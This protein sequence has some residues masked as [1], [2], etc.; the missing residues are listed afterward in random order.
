MKTTSFFLLLLFFFCFVACKGEEQTT[1]APQPIQTASKSA[2]LATYKGGQITEADFTEWMRANRYTERKI[3][4]I[5]E[6]A[7][8]QTGHLRRMALDLFTSQEAEAAG[9]DKSEAFQ[10]TVR[11]AKKNYLL[12]YFRNKLRAEA[13]FSDQAVR[14]RMIFFEVLD[15]KLVDGVK[16]VKL[17]VE[18][19]EKAYQEKI[20]LA[21]KVIKE[22]DDGAD[23]A[24]L[25][26]DYSDDPSKRVGGDIGYI[27]YQMK[28]QAF[29]DAAFSLDPGKYTTQPVRTENGVY[30]IKVEDRV[31]VNE[32][33]I[34]EKIQDFHNA[35]SL[36]R[37]LAFFAVMRYEQ[38]LKK[39]D[40]AETY[41]ANLTQKS[42][43]DTV[44]FKVSESDFTLADFDRV[45]S[46]PVVSD[47]ADTSADTVFR[48]QLSLE[49]ALLLR[50]ALK[51]GVHQQKAFKN[52]WKVMRWVALARNYK[53][54]VVLALSNIT[55]TEDEIKKEQKNKAAVKGDKVEY[56][57]DVIVKIL[58]GRKRF[59]KK[60]KYE[61]EILFKNEFTVL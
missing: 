24:K 49:D 5:L 10:T 26:K 53:N 55:I 57:R 39:A 36:K 54:A 51:Q 47:E 61:E 28:E 19:V 56:D 41:Y 60:R 58:K 6:N 22:L 34:E 21:N 48:S 43:P 12:Y 52:T 33:N 14:V 37:R 35:Q 50:E 11:H 44:L 30:L 15:Y 38:G 13:K 2:V 42:R 29:A 32:Q 8:R 31:M 18:E 17:P 1:Q 7:R 40:D 3:S 46:G 45:F 23:F 27:Y 25:A 59:A 9:F 4:G 20:G 16:Q